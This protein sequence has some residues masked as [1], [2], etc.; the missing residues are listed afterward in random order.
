MRW[1][2]AMTMAFA[3]SGGGSLGAVQVGM[4]QALAAHG[5]RADVVVGASVGALNGLHYAARPSPEGVEELARRWI[6]ISR[7]DVSPFRVDDVVLALLS[8]LPRHPVRGVQ[9]AIG[10]S[11]YA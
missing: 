8:N 11:N 2:V 6:G 3:L 4:L 7:H 1:G 5:V 10:M 9:H